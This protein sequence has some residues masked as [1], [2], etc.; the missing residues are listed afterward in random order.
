MNLCRFDLRR[1]AA[2][3]KDA[4]VEAHAMRSDEI[5]TKQ[6]APDFGTQLFKSGLLSNMFPGYAVDGRKK[7]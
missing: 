5:G 3:F 6:E 7:E 1:S 4:S 2:G